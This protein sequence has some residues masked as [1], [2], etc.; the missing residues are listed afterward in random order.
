[1]KKFLQL[2][3]CSSIL[4]FNC[5]SNT[6]KFNCAQ[7]KS[8]DARVKKSCNEL[9]AAQSKDDPIEID[10]YSVQQV[11][12]KKM[13]NNDSLIVTFV[14]YKTKDQTLSDYVYACLYINATNKIELYNQPYDEN[15]ND[16]LIETMIGEKLFKLKP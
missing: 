3:I 4:F 8:M 10:R 7:L 16:Q 15:S 9:M 6:K 14:Y 13:T 1:M 11:N 2:I 5:T 12:L